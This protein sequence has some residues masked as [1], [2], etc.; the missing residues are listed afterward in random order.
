MSYTLF[1]LQ[2]CIILI[3][4]IYLELAPA[5]GLSLFHCHVTTNIIL[6]QVQIY[7]IRIFFRFPWEMRQRGKCS[8]EVFI[9]PV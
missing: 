8:G 2:A 7:G 9:S 6:V 5:P 4:T 1:N 3:T